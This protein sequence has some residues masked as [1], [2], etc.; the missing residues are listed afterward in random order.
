MSSVSPA[1]KGKRWEVVF[2]LLIAG[3]AVFFLVE[4]FRFGARASR[5]TATI[6]A[7]KSEHVL[8]YRGVA[9]AKVHWQGK[10]SEHRVRTILWRRLAPGDEVPVVVDRRT[11]EHAH[12]DSFWQ[13]FAGQSFLVA[14]ALGRLLIIWGSRRKKA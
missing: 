5:S 13:R 7:W 6:T 10:E 12:I 9:E 8:G 3:A 11:S 1:S 4:E 2:W 14:I